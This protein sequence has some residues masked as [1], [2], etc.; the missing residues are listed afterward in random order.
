M[1]ARIRPLF[2][3]IFFVL[4]QSCCPSDEVSIS[5]NEHLDNVMLG[6]DRRFEINL[7]HLSDNSW[8]SKTWRVQTSF[9]NH[10]F[11]PFLRGLQL[12]SAINKIEN[13]EN[14]LD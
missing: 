13:V 12:V 8:H 7:L 11:T 9:R 10:S 1:F 2:V 3:L 4:F 6:F 14:F 5:V